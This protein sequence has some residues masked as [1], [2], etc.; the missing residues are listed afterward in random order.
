MTNQPSERI[1]CLDVGE[2][3]IGVSVSDLLG[4]TA[5][6]VETIFSK[7]DRKDIERILEICASYDTKKVV[8]GLPLSMNG[9]DSDQT[10]RV[11]EFAGKLTGAGL[12]VRFQDERM[13]TMLAHR[14]MLEADLSR[15]KQKQ[16]VDKIAS[17]YILQ[18][19]LDGGG[20]KQ[21]AP[22]E[23]KEVYK[24][25]DGKMEQDN[26]VELIDEEGKTVK[27]S[28]L[29]T[30]EHEKAEY[31]LL[32]PAEPMDDIGEDE[33]LILKIEEDK[34]TG[35]ES[36]V[37]VDDDD[38]LEKVFEKYLAIAEEDADDE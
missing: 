35:E 9:Q 25:M 5:Q 17:T 37:V 26:I 23:K 18:T 24:L 10:V 7:G 1:L 6:G 4:L 30:V 12:E 13:T 21:S 8:C 33:V 22:A 15:K 16:V 20:W 29:M 2:K 28:H 38:V 36:Y 3:R 14:T 11:R 31:V 32:V 27:F 34:E 19:F